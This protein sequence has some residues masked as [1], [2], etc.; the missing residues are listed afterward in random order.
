MYKTGGG[1]GINSGEGKG[2]NRKDPENPVLQVILS[3]GGRRRS[4][5]IISL[6]TEE[7]HLS[8]CTS[9]FALFFEYLVCLDNYVFKIY[10][11]NPKYII[12]KK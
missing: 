7:L 2:V 5:E 3:F 9:V 1:G 4:V 11:A 12:D 8:T 6:Q 10:Q